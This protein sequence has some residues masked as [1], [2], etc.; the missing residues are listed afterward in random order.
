MFDFTCTAFQAKVYQKVMQIPCGKVMSYASVAKAIQAGCAQAVGQ[1]LRV[2]PDN[3]LIPC[4][5]VVCTNGAL[6]GY[7]GHRENADKRKR[8]QAEGVPFVGDKVASVAFYL[9]KS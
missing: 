2:N 3:Q 4:H 9:P 7:F 1:A 8:L 6:G 5:R